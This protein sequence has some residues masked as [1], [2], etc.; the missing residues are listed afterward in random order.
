MGKLNSI[1]EE[2]ES[3]R[4]AAGWSAYMGAL[5][6]ASVLALV[7]EPLVSPSD[8]ESQLRRDEKLFWMVSELVFS[9]IF[10]IEYCLRFAVCDAAGKTTK[11]NFVKT[12]ANV[13]DLLAVV[14]T[15]VDLLL[16]QDAQALRLVRVVRLFRL[17]R[18]A[19]L[20]RLAHR[21]ALAAPVSMVLV[22]IW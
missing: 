10:T 8:E 14:P 5:I 6:V 7:M 16:H 21:T 12:P 17:T 9:I 2:P 20:A 11:W 22:V 13:C 18:M 19:R 15:Y 4:L 3:S 1:L